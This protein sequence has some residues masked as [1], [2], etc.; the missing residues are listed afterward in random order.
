MQEPMPA[1]RNADTGS[2]N[3]P[4]RITM[5]SPGWM[6]PPVPGVGMRMDMVATQ[7]SAAKS[8]D[9]TSFLA[10]KRSVIGIPP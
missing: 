9:N 2:R 7:A 1:A 8:A 5:A 4:Q 6:Y 3:T 10:V